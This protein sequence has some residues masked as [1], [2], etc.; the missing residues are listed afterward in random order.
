MGIHTLTKLLE[1]APVYKQM[2]ASLRRT[3]TLTRTQIIDEAVPFLLATL[4]KDLQ[5]PMLVI[6]PS[7][8][9]SRTLE[10]NI[11]GWV[12]KKD[13]ILRFGESDTLPF[14]RLVTDSETSQQRIN[15]LFHLTNNNNPPPIVVASAA[16]ICQTTIQRKIFEKNS[17]TLRKGDEISLEDISLHWHGMGYVFQPAVSSPG[18]AS[19]RGGILDIYPLSSEYPFRIELWGDEIDSIRT[20]DPDS[21][22]SIEEVESMEVIPARETLPTLMDFEAIDRLLARVDLSNCT[23][24]ET[25]RINGEIDLLLD[26][27]DIE[28]LSLFAGF[29]N[30]GNLLDYFPQEGLVTIY[31]P[32]NIA[33]A[34]W[35][36][37]E[38]IQQLRHVKE[39]R[40]ELPY[41]FPSNHLKWSS[42]ESSIKDR[43]RR[44][45]IMPWGAD[46]LVVQD[47]HIM[48]FSSAPTYRGD[49]DSMA[50]D[51]ETFA[52]TGGRFVASTAHSRRLGELFNEKHIPYSIPG[53]MSETPKRGT[54]MLIQTGTE[55]IGKGFV[56]N[57]PEHKLLVLGD[58][59][60]FGRTKQR[61]SARRQTA[62]REAFFDEISPGDYVVHV[63][64]GIARFTGTGRRREQSSQSDED[65]QEYLILEYFQGDRIYVP[66]DHLDR[67][68][69]YVAPMERAPSLTR[70]GTQ[71]WS[72]VKSKV[73]KSTREMAAD[74]L[75]LYAER[76]IAEGH[77]IGPDT[78][79]QTELEES[80]PYQET[81][82]Q[83][84]TLAEI[85]SDLEA[86]TPMDRLV[87]GDVGYGKTEIALRAAFKT[88]MD[89]KQVALLV[90]TTILAQQHYETF[91]GRTSAFPVE[92]EVLSRFRTDKE[93]KNVVDRLNRGEIDICIGTHRL[94]QKDVSFKDLGLII[95][96]E[97]Q[98]FGVAHKER[99]K[100]MRSQVDVLTLTA[101]PIPRTLHMSLAG[102]RDMSTIETPPEERLPVK[103]YVSEFSDDLIRE[104][105]LREVDREGQVYFLHNRVYNI[106][107]ISEYIR[108]LVPDATVG[109]AHGQM[110]EG[111]LE[112]SMLAFTRGE[113]DVL[114]CTTI[115][116]S[117]LDIPNANTLIINRADGFGLS[118]LYQ[119]RG[120]IGRSP[121]RAYSYLLIP[122]AQTLTE[123]AE[124][125]L[126]AML[127]ATE[128]GS[129]F[130][131]AMKDLEIRG[132][133]NILGTEQSGHIHAV[134]FDLYTRLLSTAVED[135]R[136]QK[137]AALEGKKEPSKIT[138]PLVNINLRIPAGIPQEYIPDLST[139]L[140]LYQRLTK[141]ISAE[142]INSIES[143]M[144][145]R[146]GPI[147]WQAINLL[148]TMRLKLKA[149]ESGAESIVRTGDKIT[150]QFPHEV[151]S[152]STILAKL[153]GYRWTIGNKQ[154]RTTI[155]GLGDDWENQ[156]IDAVD[157]LSDFQRNMT[158]RFEE[159]SE[160]DFQRSTL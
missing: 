125:R 153:L 59:E 133:G 50:Y 61:R 28:D 119:L 107:Y 92:I 132:A 105:I 82:D 113:I 149:Q 138:T 66:L 99:L 157:K 1:M 80:F 58:S 75:A 44:L 94:V 146:F 4:W 56:V 11:S 114:V 47:M 39:N 109:I 143:E 69:P 32:E 140:D 3:S 97:E 88:V 155:D 62:R 87:C 148:Y 9:H 31:K 81:P 33:S 110:S 55:N 95:I 112:K 150:L 49:V 35:D 48:P 68:A 22:R 156:L 145:D 13:S 19:R 93:Q 122:R 76:E 108:L 41:N 64:H 65:S 118:Q 117:G 154:I 43:K 84:S 23:E 8:E 128:L 124:R 130:R 6:C 111:E 12:E 77:S 16:A 126:K 25:H 73:E 98:R 121:R 37:E 34:A 90:P 127:S 103:T 63:E 134:G 129:G 70:L 67:V 139:R 38:R 158:A 52:E 160:G 100:Q 131:I 74:L 78:R 24:E 72:R 151:S 79:W 86:T 2:A 27:H 15:T 40:G 135:L 21:Q 18:E 53:N 159:A 17:H 152:V 102:V 45:L 30:H 71:E 36:I 20:F 137:A 5:V 85:K 116:E 123:S 142:D 91:S 147:P 29:F 54:I 96:D 101:T 106:E 57:I 46:D 14:E 115:I 42:L 51:A 141:T 26:G 120:R 60:I 136:A 10:E 144:K 83:I 104:A 7:S 89:G